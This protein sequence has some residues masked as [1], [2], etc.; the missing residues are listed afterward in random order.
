MNAP[1]YVQIHVISEVI[2]ACLSSYKHHSGMDVPQ[3][4]HTDVLSDFLLA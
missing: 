2:L 4:V 1:H 3:N